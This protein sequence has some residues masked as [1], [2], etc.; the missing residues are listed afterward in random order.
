MGNILVA[1]TEK[2]ICTVKL[3][4]TKQELEKI[5]YKEFDRGELVCD[6]HIHQDWVKIILNFIDGNQPHLDLPIDVRG[7]TFQKQVWQ[8]LQK[9]PYGETCTY[10]DIANQ[11]NKPKSVRAVGKACGANQ[12]ALIIPCHRVVKNDGSLG[13]YRWGIER[14]QKLLNQESDTFGHR[15]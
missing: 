3:G 15:L 12:I 14:K 7:T 9:I 11:I 5:I 6:R 13:G 1:T 4:D 8:V 10:K 2:G